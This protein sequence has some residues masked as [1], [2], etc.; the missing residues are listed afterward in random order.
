MTTD[1]SI[2]QPYSIQGYPTLNFFGDTKSSPTDYNGGRTSKEIT[3]FLMKQA[4][5][6]VNKR[7][8]GKSS[9]SESKS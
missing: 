1:Q 2:G 3:S 9:K 5:D 6:I 7:L 8:G 4:Q